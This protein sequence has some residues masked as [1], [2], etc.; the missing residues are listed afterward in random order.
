MS[1]RNTDTEKLG[2]REL[3]AIGVGGMVGGG[4]FS[5][6]GLS[7]ALSGHAAPLAFSLGAVIALITGMSY[8]RLGLCFRDDGG[9]FTYLEH[10]FKS[11][12]IAGIGG[13]L[14]IT[15]Y[16]GTLALYAFTFGVYG[17]AMLGGTEVI[18]HVLET[19]ILLLFLG[20]NLYGVQA[21]GKTEDIIVIIK[22]L[23]LGLFAVAGLVF[24]KPENI[25]PIINKGTSGILMGAALIFVAYEGF[26]LIPNAVNEMKNPEKD[27]A[28]GIMIAIIITAIIYFIV[29]LV[30]VGNL[31]PEDIKKYKEYA[32]AVAAKPFLGQAGFTLI[33]LGALLS[34]ASAINATL[35]GTARL[36]MVMAQEKDLPKVFSYR[37]RSKDIP[38]VSLIFI[39]VVTIIFVNTTN[40]SIISSFASSTFLLT[41]VGINGAAMKLRDRIKISV[42][43]PLTGLIL[44]GA[45]WLVLIVYLWRTDFKAL[46]WIGAFYLAVIVAELIF[47]KRRLILRKV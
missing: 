4:I 6:L 10:A 18:H 16:I 13:W 47:S 30:A 21:A 31:T 44:S 33:G 43:I 32:L 29:S 27:L 20:V 46:T 19:F 3:I 45:S 41:F 24:M 2:L 25:F 26:E 40:L 38:Y 1:Q 7:V 9:S 17:T 39:T 37:E 22:V 34:T 23:I 11:K 14:L 28:R 15:G 36:G 5:V 12:N 8:S 35:F 42:G